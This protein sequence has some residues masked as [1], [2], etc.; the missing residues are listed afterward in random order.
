MDLRTGG[1]REHLSAS[2]N[3]FLRSALAAALAGVLLALLTLA[4]HDR[5]ARAALLANLVI[6]GFYALIE[7]L[8][9]IL[10]AAGADLRFLLW[11][12]FNYGVP[13]L[14]ALVAATLAALPPRDQERE[15]RGAAG[16]AP[17]PRLLEEL[18]GE[19]RARE[20]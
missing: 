3:D 13:L 14:I 2:V 7:P 6:L 20:G 17:R 1:P 11:A 16:N 12:E 19:P 18:H 15:P 9:V 10:D 8:D 4:V 5:T